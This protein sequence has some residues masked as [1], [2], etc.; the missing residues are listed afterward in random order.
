LFTGAGVPPQIVRNYVGI[1]KAYSTRVGGGPFP[2]E[3][4]NEIGDY[5]RQRGN[6]YGT[7][8]GR[9]RRC[10][11]FDAM[12]VRYS[13]D[14]CGITAVALTLIDVLSGLDKVHICTGYKSHGRRLDYFRAD[15][16]TLAEVEPIYESLPGWRGN[17]TGC[18]HFEEPEYVLNYAR[19]P[20]PTY[21]GDGKWLVVGQTLAG[22]YMQVVFIFD[23]DQVVYVIHA[24]PITQAEKRRY[25]RRRKR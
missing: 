17:L 4:V 11:W 15:M 16:D 6:E 13:V 21:R 10:G 5:I 22:R 20:Y 9:P 18:R 23:L 7:T 25:R 3:Q 24:R 19:L 1:M 14:L 12:A 8:T 2:T